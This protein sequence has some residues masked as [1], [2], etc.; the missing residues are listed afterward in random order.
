MIDI[1]MRRDEN[2]VA[3]HH[4]LAGDAGNV[5]CLIKL[6]DHTQFYLEK[7]CLIVCMT[8]DI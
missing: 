2:C 4:S 1:V 6:P 8:P 3:I 7:F 5:R